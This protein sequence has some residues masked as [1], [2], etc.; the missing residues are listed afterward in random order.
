MRGAHI[1]VCQKNGKK[2]LEIGHDEANILK[3]SGNFYLTSPWTG[4]S[5]NRPHSGKWQIWDLKNKD[6]VVEFQKKK[7]AIEYFQWFIVQK[8]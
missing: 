8:T 7:D 1:V 4:G 6:L 2:V 3:K 5:L